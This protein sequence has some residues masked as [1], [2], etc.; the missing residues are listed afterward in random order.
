MKNVYIHIY[1]Y[2]CIHQHTH[3]NTNTHTHTHT[4]AQT[5][6]HALATHRRLPERELV[7]LCP[8]ETTITAREICLLLQSY[9]HHIRHFMKY[10]TSS[11]KIFEIH[12]V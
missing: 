4:H 7:L 1:I 8:C 12:N 2:V 10:I 6:T 5:Q 3:T 9:D 11:E